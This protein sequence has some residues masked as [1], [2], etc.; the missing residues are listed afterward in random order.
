MKMGVLMPEV[1]K[2]QPKDVHGAHRAAA[3]DD[4]GGG[5]WE[6]VAIGEL[7]K[8]EVQNSAAKLKFR[9]QEACTH[10]CGLM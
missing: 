3:C 5:S 4:R 10:H 8:V 6:V 9:R 7:S 1:T 2:F